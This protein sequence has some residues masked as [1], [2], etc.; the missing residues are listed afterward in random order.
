MTNYKG[1]GGQ[2][3]GAG[4]PR[5]SPEETKTFRLPISIGEKAKSGFYED[6]EALIND[7]IF[8]AEDHG[9]NSRDWTKINEFLEEY[10]K[11]KGQYK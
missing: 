8:R 4:R 3:E 7:W 10:N 9:A 6:I 1:R 11:I 2:R 5:L